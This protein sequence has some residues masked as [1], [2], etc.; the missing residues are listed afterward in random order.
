MAHGKGVAGVGGDLHTL[1]ALATLGFVAQSFALSRRLRLL[2]RQG[3]AS[4]M[5]HPWGGR[6]A[7]WS[8]AAFFW[9]L[10]VIRPT[11]RNVAL[12]VAIAVSLAE[13]VLLV[14]WLSIIRDQA[15]R[16]TNLEVIG[17]GGLAALFWIW[18]FRSRARTV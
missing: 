14:N 5:P 13:L 12:A 9:L 15:A 6:V 8:G 7:Y 3:M 2:F 16:A 17:K 11:R 18:H 4:A 10:Y 1:A